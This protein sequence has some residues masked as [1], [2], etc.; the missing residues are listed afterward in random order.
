MQALPTAMPH[1][2]NTVTFFAFL[3]LI[4]G[5]QY[6]ASYSKALAAGGSE[7][8]ATHVAQ[9]AAL[10][11]GVFSCF[12]L[13]LCEVVCAASL[14]SGG[15]EGGGWAAVCAYELPCARKGNGYSRTIQIT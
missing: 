8:H 2:I 6:D 10:E 1:G 14:V 12:M 11:A 5:P 15:S 13:G 3:A 9:Q 7:A 4:I